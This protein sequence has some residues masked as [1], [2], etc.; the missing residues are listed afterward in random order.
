MKAQN[1]VRVFT[2][3]EL[4][5]ANRLFTNFTHYETLD[6]GEL[7][8]SYFERLDDA[9]CNGFID[10]EQL[11]EA[12]NIIERLTEIINEASSNIYFIA[13]RQYRL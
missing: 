5:N 3:T 13:K 9:I 4:D 2:H 8:D 12:R 6:N 7:A 11:L 1:K 10:S